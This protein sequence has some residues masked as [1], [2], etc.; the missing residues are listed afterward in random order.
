ML[1]LSALKQKYEELFYSDNIDILQKFMKLSVVIIFFAHALA[2]LF[3]LVGVS[4]SEN[5]QSWPVRFGLND[6]SIAV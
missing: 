3:W 1:K 4:T 6:E 5:D 2:C